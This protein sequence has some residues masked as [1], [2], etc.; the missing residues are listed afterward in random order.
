M[1]IMIDIDDIL[2]NFNL[3][4]L[5]IANEMFEEV[6]MDVEVKVWDFWKSV[7]NLTL[8][9]EER[10]WERIRNTPNFYEFLPPYAS[11]KEL[12]RLGSLVAQGCHEFYFITSR[13]P[14]KGRSVQL[15]SQ[16]WIQKKIGEPVSVIVSSRK[17]ELC[18]VLGIDYAVDD[19]PHHVENLL[20]HG[21]N[22][23]IMDWP[24]NRHIDHRLRVKNLG[25]FLDSVLV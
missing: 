12:K 3:A 8:D 2:S 16:R 5:K 23:Y 14:T 11:P 20:D 6:P 17:G 7:P 4:F 22:T 10:V 24:Y 19:A 13:F 1:K 15:Q 9:M 25:E 18:K 21:I